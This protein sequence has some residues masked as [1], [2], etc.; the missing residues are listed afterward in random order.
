MNEFG[1]HS[2]NPRSIFVQM[3]MRSFTKMA[4]DML[5]NIYLNRGTVFIV[6]IKL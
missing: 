1:K 3:R 5:R 4:A 6:I 2:T